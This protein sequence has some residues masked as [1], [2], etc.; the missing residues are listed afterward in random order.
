[1]K[2]LIPLILTLLIILSACSPAQP[3]TSAELPDGAL[4]AAAVTVYGIQKE[5]LQQTSGEFAPFADTENLALSA[6]IP[7]Y[8]WENGALQRSEQTRWL[9]LA[10]GGVIGAF[11]WPLADDFA[12]AGAT[13]FGLLRSG[14]QSYSPRSFDRLGEEAVA[15]MNHCLS[16]GL[17]I[18]F[19][20]T[21]LETWLLH[22][23]EATRLNNSYPDEP[24][25][26][27]KA[28]LQAAKGLP[29][30]TLKAVY[31]FSMATWEEFYYQYDYDR[32]VYPYAHLNL[33]DQIRATLLTQLRS[34]P[35]D[36]EAFHLAEPLKIY[37]ARDGEIKEE[38]V[39]LCPIF[40]GESCI[41]YAKIYKDRV[42]QLRLLLPMEK[43]DFLDRLSAAYAKGTKIALLEERDGCYLLTDDS[44]RLVSHARPQMDRDDLGSTADVKKTAARLTQE[45]I[46]LT[47]TFSFDLPDRAADPMAY[48]VTVNLL[49]RGLEIGQPMDLTRIRIGQAIPTHTYG[50]NEQLTAST[51]FLVPLLQ[52]ESVIGAMYW[53]ASD[54]GDGSA[55]GVLWADEDPETIAALQRAYESGAECCRIEDAQQIWLVLGD[56]ILQ[57]KRASFDQYKG[58]FE[59]A[60]IVAIAAQYVARTAISPARQLMP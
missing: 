14:F 36:T 23:K 29:L 54:T 18:A 53:Y 35:V 50:R 1:M 55:G 10:D 20:Q 58:C 24:F 45:K 52:D 42:L 25:A 38:P 7:I 39:L 59:S 37:T 60:D 9:M 19:V 48:A 31:P 21:E 46:A 41:G 56:E 2:R 22:G 27:A 11:D 33:T 44:A 40:A 51:T 34:A 49:C 4:F 6:P 47:E 28:V 8:I 15:L 32:F 30:A 3:D 13:E 43:S 26:D 17:R 12:P 16:E 57:Q 5:Y